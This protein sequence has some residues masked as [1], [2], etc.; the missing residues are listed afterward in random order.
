MVVHEVKFIKSYYKMFQE[1]KPLNST[2]KCLCAVNCGFQFVRNCSFQATWPFSFKATVLQ[3]SA[4]LIWTMQF[5]MM[6]IEFKTVY[7][8]C[9]CHSWKFLEIRI[10]FFFFFTNDLSCTVM[11]MRCIFLQNMA[12]Q[13]DLS[14]KIQIV[15]V[16]GTEQL[17]RLLSDPD[18]AVL[19]KTLGLI[20]NLL[21]GRTVIFYL[22]IQCTGI[23]LLL[24]NFPL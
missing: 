5:R 2:R 21:S 15:D 10:F 20:R 13:A 1:I 18:P 17:F 3:L 12:F 6:V 22:T 8:N 9:I 11:C 16:I 19:I 24:D 14:V 23:Y 7:L 4:L